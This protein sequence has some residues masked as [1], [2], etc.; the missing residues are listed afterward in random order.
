MIQRDIFGITDA[1]YNYLSAACE[2]CTLRWK[3]SDSTDAQDYEEVKPTV[4]EYTFDDANLPSGPSVLIQTTR[5]NP[6]SIHYVM[7]ISCYHPAVQECEIA[8]R[9]ENT[10][11]YKYRTDETDNQ[12]VPARDYSSGGVRRELYRVT[13]MLADYVFTS[14]MRMGIDSAR[15]QGLTMIPPSAYMQSFPECDCTIEFD[16]VYVSKPVAIVGTELSDLL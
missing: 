15:L 12:T 3:K 14:L 13:L 9:Q 16:A 5:V 6:D 4:Y 1:I 2:G 11:I 8:D 7:Y 10:D